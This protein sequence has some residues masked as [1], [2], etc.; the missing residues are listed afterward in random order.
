MSSLIEEINIFGHCKKL[1]VPIWS[2]PRFVFLIM[3]VLISFSIITA[4]FVARQYTEPEIVI[5]MV[6][7]LT[8]FLM[9]IMYILVNAFERVVY[10]RQ[11]EA[12][13]TKDILELKDQ[14]VHIAV[15]DLASSA[16]A[17]KWGLKTL[18]PK[19]V[20]LSDLEKEMFVNIRER[21][22]QLITLSRRIL[23]ITRIESGHL[24]VTPLPINIT[25]T[26]SAIKEEVVR[27]ADE[28]QVTIEQVYPNDALM[29]STDAV[30]LR[31]IILVLLKNAI[32]YSNPDDGKVTLTVNTEND[33]CVIS[34]A[35]NGASIS[36]EHRPHIFEKYWRDSAENK[37]EGTSFGMY[38]AKELTLKLGGTISF[39]SD[40]EQTIFSVTL[41]LAK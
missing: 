27:A 16:T 34:V 14:F 39:T 36:P 38:I 33:H 4:Y 8:I 32:R 1:E 37:I 30:H 15:H 25:E 6:T 17:I 12:Q 24:E 23:L 7:L 20:G 10:S 41:P 2:C 19:L 3:G 31:E 18:E 40:P 5:G 11:T 13:R 26:I 28:H 35:H 21:N 29:I 9:A 22:E